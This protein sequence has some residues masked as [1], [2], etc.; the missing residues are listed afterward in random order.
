[1]TMATASHHSWWSGIN[2]IQYPI[3]YAQLNYRNKDMHSPTPPER[4]KPISSTVSISISRETI[5]RHHLQ[6]KKN[7]S[8]CSRVKSDIG[9]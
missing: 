8:N 5:W 1:M 7:E 2:I 3:S 9:F 6:G 4:N